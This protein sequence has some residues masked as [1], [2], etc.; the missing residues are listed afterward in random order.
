MESVNESEVQEAVRKG[1]PS[2]NVDRPFTQL[3]EGIF[4]ESPWAQREEHMV[5]FGLL[6]TQE[7]PDGR[8]EFLPRRGRKRTQL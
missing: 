6:H 1:T 8:A 2:L 4:N 7:G 3:P 5:E